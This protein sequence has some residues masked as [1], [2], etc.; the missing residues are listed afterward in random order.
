MLP[1][2]NLP[3]SDSA[4]F[5][6]EPNTATLLPEETLDP[7]VAFAD[8]LQLR[9]ASPLEVEY[10]GGT[11]LPRSGN[12]LPMPAPANAAKA[13]VMAGEDAGIALTQERQIEFPDSITPALDSARDQG[14]ARPAPAMMT[15][16]APVAAPVAAPTRHEFAPE[17]PPQKIQASPPTT[18]SGEMSA[19]PQ[20][21]AAGVA[22]KPVIPLA[23]ESRSTRS[24]PMPEVP[25]SPLPPVKTEE[26]AMDPRASTPAL[27]AAQ[28]AAHNP[29]PQVQLDTVA[30][31]PTAGNSMQLTQSP[32]QPG[33]T[34]SAPSPQQL[35]SIDVPVKDGAWGSQIGDRVLLM[36]SNKLQSA[37]IRL[38]PA[39]LGPLRV[40]VA[41]DD[42]AA[43]VTF[44]AQHA[45]TREA[46]EQALP[47]LRE[48]LA[49]NGL[50]LNQA[51]ISEQGEQGEHGVRHGGRDDAQDSRSGV[52]QATIAGEDIEAGGVDSRD[53]RQVQRT[54]LVDT[55]A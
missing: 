19:L 31:Q 2:M 10:D 43:N 55:F 29:G 34:A 36:A 52:S 27:P 46:I 53:L 45:V 22:G 33:N 16:A 38:T 32:V 14:T 4:V 5:D 30:M 20:V 1:L 40:Q 6:L 41:L 39:E 12:E 26:L 51:S 23:P 11:G 13:K 54:G 37:E 25:L 35:P 8:I 50:T 24:A 3:T 18:L 21:E 28:V 49:D 9:A 48:L 44:H 15:P 47:R 17:R 7:A 42:A